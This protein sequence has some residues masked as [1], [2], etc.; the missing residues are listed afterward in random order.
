MAGVRALEQLEGRVAV[1]V[2]DRE[3]H[4]HAVEQRVRLGRVRLAARSQLRLVD[5]VAVAAV[6]LR[7]HLCGRVATG[8]GGGSGGAGH[9]PAGAGAAA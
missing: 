5:G 3:G 4:Q 7:E 1:A 6:Q 9:L 2:L 8:G